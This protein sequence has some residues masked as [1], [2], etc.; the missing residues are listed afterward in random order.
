MHLA[1]GKW[2]N[3]AD[4]E[5]RR[6]QDELSKLRREMLMRQTRSFRDTRSPA[7][8]SDNGAHSSIQQSAYRSRQQD[9]D[10]LSN[11]VQHLQQEVARL[12]QE[13]DAA[14][15]QSNNSP[16]KQALNHRPIGEIFSHSVALVSLM[17]CMLFAVHL[18][19]YR[20]SRGVVHVMHVQS[21]LLKLT[22][23]M[24]YLLAQTGSSA[25]CD[26]WSACVD[27]AN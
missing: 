8:G 17:Q 20:H 5:H 21:S 18:H 26:Q 9:Q 4:A 3:G 13:R 7:P 19:P 15:M 25:C 6:M 16:S 1:N 22:M 24:S 23:N 27:C 2:D 12:R 11:E 10:R 14:R